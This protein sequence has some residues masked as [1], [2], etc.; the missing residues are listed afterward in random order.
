MNN[1]IPREGQEFVERCKNLSYTELDDL[2]IE[3]GNTINAIKAQIEYAHAHGYTTN[4]DGDSTWESKAQTALRWNKWR[5]EVATSYKTRARQ[6]SSFA[7]SFM[8]CARAILPPLQYN[9]VYE[10]ALSVHS[11]Q[12]TSLGTKV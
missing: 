12:D 8:E 5:L 3:L 1:H 7:L 6:S 9:L 11:E 2:C 4:K 10:E